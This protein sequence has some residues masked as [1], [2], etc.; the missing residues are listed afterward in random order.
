VREGRFGSTT[1]PRAALTKPLIRK[2]G[3]PKSADFVMDPA[4]PL[5][6]FAKRAGTRRWR[7]RA[8]AREDPRHARRRRVGGLRVAEELQRGSVPVPEA[9]AHRL[10][11]EQRRPLR[12]SVTRRASPR[13]W[14]ASAPARSSNPVMD[15]MKADVVL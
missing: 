3:M 15:V 4:D 7:W 8:R 13:S 2:P 9:R 12:A 6:V 10:S 14:K 1:S 5:A 11:H